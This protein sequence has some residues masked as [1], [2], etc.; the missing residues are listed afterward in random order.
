[1]I[2]RFH[3]RDDA[4][5][6]GGP[7]NVSPK[8]ASTWHELGLTCRAQIQLSL[9]HKSDDHIWFTFFHEAA[10]IVLHGKKEVFIEWDAPDSDKE[11]QANRFA[12]ETLIPAAQWRRIRSLGGY[13]KALIRK[14]AAEAG[15]SPGILVGRLQHDKLL[16]P[17]HCNDLKGRYE[18]RLPNGS[19]GQAGKAA[20]W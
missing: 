11:Q 18:F 19:Q 13:S 3:G 14:L 4:S 1:V 17:S 15:I 5:S 9:R 2:G 7:A 16:P 20:R 12:A 10:H 8:N 6:G